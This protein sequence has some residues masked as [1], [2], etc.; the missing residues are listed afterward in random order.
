MPT[1]SVRTLVAR[2]GL[3]QHADGG[4]TSPCPGERTIR[5]RPAEQAAGDVSSR[6]PPAAL[7]DGRIVQLRQDGRARLVLAEARTPAIVEAVADR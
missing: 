7:W 3:P 2:N 6:A 5:A 4:D 1:A